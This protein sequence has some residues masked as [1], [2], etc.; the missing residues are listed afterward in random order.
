MN[1]H[2]HLKC[3]SVSRLSSSHSGADYAHWHFEE[4]SGINLSIINP[5]ESVGN[6]RRL[7]GFQFRNLS[8]AKY[9]KFLLPVYSVQNFESTA[10]NKR[11][12]LMKHGITYYRRKTTNIRFC[13]KFARGQE[14]PLTLR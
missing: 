12:M 8:L 6:S 7:A 1:Q 14:Y 3:S 9:Y 13:L 4:V 5:A 2:L 11:A 10:V